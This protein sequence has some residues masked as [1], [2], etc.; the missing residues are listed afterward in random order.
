M[1]WPLAHD[2]RTRT[3]I[4]HGIVMEPQP[5]NISK[6]F[7]QSPFSE[8]APNFQHTLRGD[9]ATPQDFAKPSAP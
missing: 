5:Y 8:A 6:F 3:I 2:C 4:P 1:R 9:V 7:V